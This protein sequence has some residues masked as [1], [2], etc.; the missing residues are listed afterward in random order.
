MI[1]NPFVLSPYKNKELFCDRERETEELIRNL[2]NGRNVTLISPRR[3]GKTG[4]IY[5]VFDELSARGSEF[6]T[7]YV[8]IS[9]SQNINGF[10]KLLA[11]AV[12]KV[13][14]RQEKKR[15]FF[16]VL[17]GIRPLLSY[18]AISGQPQISLTYQSEEERDLT[19]KNILT[20]LEN[21]TRK[22]ILAIDEFQQIR[23]YA[24]MDMEA[25]LRTYIQPLQNVRFIF[26]GSKKHVMT[27]I[28][29]NAKRPFYESS[30]FLSLGKLDEKKY[31]DFIIRLFGEGGKTISD[32]QVAYIISWTKDYT[33]YTQFLCNEVFS[34]SGKVVSDSDI[35]QSII[36]TLESNYDRFLEIRQLIT[37]AQW[38]LMK[39]IAQEGS[40]DHPTA[41]SFIQKHQLGSGAAVSKNIKSLVEKELILK[42]IS[43]NGVSYSV[44]NVFLSRYLERG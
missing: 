31:S 34:R 8:D 10:I 9:S 28:F 4:L 33:F 12:I 16:K 1:E 32:E 20:F 22:V 41:A 7:F 40:V 6:D 21:N 24:G 17:G 19:L 5:R 15:A 25:L 30:V 13:L 14:K 38:R 27:D 36:S 43:L 26:C 44:Y 35:R 11:E 42:D 37:P 18:D 23:E 2:S 39:A 3:L 29:S